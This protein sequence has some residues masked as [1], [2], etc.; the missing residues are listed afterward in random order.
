MKDLS[1]KCACLCRIVRF[2]V[3]LLRWVGVCLVGFD[4]ELWDAGKR[5]RK[6]ALLLFLFGSGLAYL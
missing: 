4:E 1:V 2:G 3:R 5:G 6:L